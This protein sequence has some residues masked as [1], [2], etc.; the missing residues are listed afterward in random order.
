MKFFDR[1]IHENLSGGESRRLELF[2]S[3]IEKKNRVFLFDEPDSGVDMK[4]VKRIGGYISDLFKEKSNSGILI[5]H[6]REILKYVKGNRE[7]TI[8]DGMI[9]KGGYVK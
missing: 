7:I 9:K 4:N 5:T 1:D 8:D 2:L 6:S 3:T